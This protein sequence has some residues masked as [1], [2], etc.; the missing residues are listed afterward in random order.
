[1]N[2]TA[3]KVTAGSLL[4]ALG[5]IYGDIGTSPL[6][7]YKAILGHRVI[8]EVLVY[9]GVSCV[10][11]TLVFQTSIKYIWLT[12]RADNDGE[13]GIFSLYALVRRFGKGLV[14]PTMIGAAALLADGLITPPISIMSAVEGLGTIKG[15]EH[16][17]TLPIVIGLITIFFLFQRFGTQKVGSL[18]GPIMTVWFSM[19]FVLGINQ[20]IHHPDIIKALNPYYAFELLVRYPGGFWIL[21]AVFLATTG[22]EALYFDLGHCGIKNIRITWVF[23]KIC[24]VTNYLGQAAWAMQHLQSSLNGRSPFF[25]IMPTWFL[26][27]GILIATAAAIIASQAVISGSY[28]LISEAV[29]L[30]FWPRVT[31]RQPSETKGQIYVPSINLLLWVG[32]V[33]IVLFFRTSTSMEAAYG[34]AIILAMMMTTTLLNSYLIYRLK[35]NRFATIGIIGLFGTIEMSFFIANIKKFPEGGYLTI[36]LAFVFFLVMY[37]IYHG[38]RISNKMT[39]WVNLD[40]YNPSLKEL[41]EDLEIPKFATHVIYLTKANT[42]HQIEQ[43]II[44]SILSKNPKRADVYWFLHLHRTEAPYTLEYN[45]HE[46]LDDKV[47]KVN[48]HIGFRVQPLTELYFKQIVRELVRKKELNLHTRADGST[49]YN[50]EPDFKFVVIEKYISVENQ[51]TASEG[52]LLNSYFFLKNLGLSDEKAFGLDKSDVVIES[53]PLVIHPVEDVK[54]TRQENSHTIPNP[55][56]VADK[57]GTI[58]N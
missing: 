52:I 23:V 28:T 16:I 40:D 10:F 33:L 19:L 36:L 35:W 54:L 53:I 57:I 25:E 34:L 24:L 58:S 6:Y 56:E 9:G 3:S 38:R 49:K 8:D 39:K 26:I 15:L 44:N 42:K 29:H 37:G 46:L 50:A 5:I 32:C 51:F 55:K 22:A 12:L 13:G 45:V 1:M 17:P 4:I 30:N 48:L 18:F 41:S 11:W 7:A 47:I 27:I 21:G 14:L 31:I 2:K 20:I 43:K